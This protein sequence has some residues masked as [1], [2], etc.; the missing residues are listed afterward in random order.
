MDLSV[1]AR[2]MRSEYDFRCRS[3]IRRGDNDPANNHA[4]NGD[5]CQCFPAIGNIPQSIRPQNLLRA[6]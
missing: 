4:S 6:S 2:G 1:V 3:Y 5:R